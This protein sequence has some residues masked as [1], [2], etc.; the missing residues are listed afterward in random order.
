MGVSINRLFQ[1]I[2][3]LL[4]KKRVTAAELAEEFDVSTRTVYRD[5]DDLSMAGIPVYTT[6]GRS[7]GISLLNNYVLD[8]SLLSATEQEQI[9]MALKNVS[10]V[11]P[12]FD[13]LLLKMSALFQKKDGDWMEVDLSR[14]GNGS[15]DN[16][17]FDRLR[18]GILEKQV[19]TFL[20]VNGQ[21]KKSTKTIQPAKLVF[22]SKAWY[23]Q[24]FCIGAQDY[25]T[26]K[27]NR[28]GEVTVQS[29]RFAEIL[30]PP[31]IEDYLHNHTFAKI[32]L[33]FDSCM[34]HRVYEEF[35]DSDITLDNEGNLIVATR[36]PEDAWLYGYLFSFGSHLEVLEPPRLRDFLAKEALGILNLYD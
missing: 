14:W 17:K 7:G 9:L 23:L 2:N 3:I 8:K 10:V 22:K 19:V 34:A 4:D 15:L 26:Y 6:Q 30:S 33:K 18:R 31:P 16:Q 27:L 21:G 13:S 36:M 29:E 28:I 32:T 11:S 1:I 12:D 5:I 24:G 20:Y 35:D 25:R